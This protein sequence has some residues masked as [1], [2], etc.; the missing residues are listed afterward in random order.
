M[1]CL[2]FVYLLTT[3][4]YSVHIVLCLILY[5]IVLSVFVLFKFILVIVLTKGTSK[6]TL[7]NYYVKTKKFEYNYNKTKL[8]YWLFKIMY[9]KNLSIN[10]V[11]KY[12]K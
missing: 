2:F 12:S 10:T 8:L 7:K 4:V 1:E 6:N 3:V 5:R 11:S 9:I